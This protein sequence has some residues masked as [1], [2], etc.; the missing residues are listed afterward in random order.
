[1]NRWGM[2]PDDKESVIKELRKVPGVS[3]KSAEAMYV[4]GIRKAEDL[5]GKDPVAMYEELRGRKDFY[6]EPCMLNSFKVA[7]KAIQA[8]KK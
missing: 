6:V 1:M 2:S 3:E 7:V 5:N 8:S 4:L